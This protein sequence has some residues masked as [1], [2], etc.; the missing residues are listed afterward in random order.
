MSRAV[1]NAAS[2]DTCMCVSLVMSV[3]CVKSAGRL[4]AVL[5]VGSTEQKRGRTT[6]FEYGKEQVGT[7]MSEA[8]T[9]DRVG[10][11]LRG[12]AHLF[13]PTLQYYV[14][15]EDVD[16]K[17]YF[18]NRVAQDDC[19]A[20]WRGS[21]YRF[22]DNLKNHEPTRVFDDGYNGFFPRFEDLV[23]ATDTVVAFTPI[24]VNIFKIK[25]HYSIAKTPSGYTPPEASYFLPGD[26]AATMIKKYDEASHTTVRAEDEDGKSPQQEVENKLRKI[27]ALYDQE[28]IT[29]EDFEKKK[30]ELL[31][32]I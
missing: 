12:L 13:A 25:R 2:C 31:D 20:T 26:N 16:E 4:D 14:A 23:F 22:I 8:S 6:G 5:S 11:G 7:V 32:R 10:R 18:N 1:H 27:K 19:V 15:M 29:A 28:L 17:F 24:P 30:S 9:V 3:R 21:E